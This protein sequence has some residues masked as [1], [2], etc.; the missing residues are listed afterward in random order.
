MGSDNL[1]YSKGT[2]VA[3]VLMFSLGLLELPYFAYTLIKLSG[4]IA[5]GYIAATRVQRDKIFGFSIFFAVLF[6]PFFRV[7]LVREAW[8]VIDVLAGI[9]LT[10]L[11]MKNSPKLEKVCK[12]RPVDFKEEFKQF[13]H[14]L[15]T[16]VTL[17]EENSWKVY[18]TLIVELGYARFENA[19]ELNKLNFSDVTDPKLRNRIEIVTY[20]TGR[21]FGDP[22]I[23]A[24]RISVRKTIPMLFDIP[25]REEKS[26]L[27]VSNG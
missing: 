1:I 18:R 24:Y 19:D 5:F 3:L 17:S 14:D 12:P 2:T 7:H 8:M 20:R 21:D 27:M 6:N 15:K 22:T 4:F 9:L 11:Y 10:Y 16:N 23:M 26:A 13:Q 25:L